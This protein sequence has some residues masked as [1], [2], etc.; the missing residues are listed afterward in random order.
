MYVRV[1]EL[2]EIYDINIVLNFEM[3]ACSS[4]IILVT[5]SFHTLVLIV[6]KFGVMLCNYIVSSVTIFFIYILSQH[7]IL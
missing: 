5:I 4:I 1:K 7:M 6:V 2:T 3:D